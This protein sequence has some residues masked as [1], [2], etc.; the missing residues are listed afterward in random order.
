MKKKFVFDKVENDI[1]SI[2]ES[3]VIRETG[4]DAAKVKESVMKEIRNEKKTR[5]S[6]F[7]KVFSIFAIAAALTAAATVSTMAATGAFNPAF[8]ELFAGQPANGIFPGSDISVNSDS[9]NIE[10]VGVTGDETEMLS[11]YNITKKDGSSFVDTADNYCFLGNNSEMDVSESS[12]KQLK[13]FL[14]GGCGRS[15]GV[16]YDFVDEKTIRAVASYSDTAGCIKGERLT[17]KDK[18]TT[19]YHIDEVLYSDASDSFEGC[20]DYMEKN[21]EYLKEK[22]ASLKENQIMIPAILDGHANYVVATSTTIPFEY[23][24]GVKLNYKTTERAFPEVVGRKFNVLNTE[25]SIESIQAGSFG[26]KLRAVTDHSNIYA[27]F[28]MDNSEN[29][30]FETL[31]DYFNVPT[32]ITL[33]ITLKDGTRVIAKGYAAFRNEMQG[34]GEYEWHCTYVLDS[35]QSISYA[36]DSNNI[37]SIVCNGTELI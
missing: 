22:E 12:Y 18:E 28:D 33:N 2:D 10:F 26:L 15:S 19:F 34:H 27:G 9:L 11:I 30:S 7:K 5:K 32:D 17:V 14:D 4:V 3:T 13:I 20:T 29:W 16:S 24:L 37:A 25:W 31:H 21:S 6:S 35:D 36:L 1:V 8:G 23:E